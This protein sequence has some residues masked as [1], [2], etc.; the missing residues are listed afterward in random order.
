MRTELFEIPAPFSGRLAIAP[1]PRGGDWLDEELR[2]W[3]ESGIDV[4]V[5]L[6]TPEEAGEFELE[7]EAAE[8]GAQGIRFRAFP[9]PDRE[10]PASRTLFHDLVSEVVY[11]LTAGHEVV[12][13]CR[14]GIG[15]ASLVAISILIAAGLDIEMAVKRVSEVRGRPVPETPVQRRWLDEWAADTKASSEVV[16]SRP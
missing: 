14:Q 12:I 16:E 8:A 2:S 11:E 9:I 1:R 10:A 7:R 5:S 15:R 3:H 4:V 6:L 13:H